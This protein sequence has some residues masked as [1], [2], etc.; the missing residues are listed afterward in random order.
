VRRNRGIWAF[1]VCL[2]LPALWLAGTTSVEDA[3]SVALVGGVIATAGL[4]LAI[5]WRTHLA[6]ALLANR[7]ATCGHTMCYTRPGE[8]KPPAGSTA[9]KNCFWRCRHCGR[10]V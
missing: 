5:A 4:T 1:L 9:T 6:G 10:L 3:R 8:V 7:C 2:A